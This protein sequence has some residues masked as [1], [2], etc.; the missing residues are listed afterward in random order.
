MNKEEENFEALKKAVLREKKIAGEISAVF[1]VIA[2]SRDN[3]EKKMMTSQIDSLKDAL[4]KT[5]DELPK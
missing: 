3:H 4:K 1:S 5:N 2:K